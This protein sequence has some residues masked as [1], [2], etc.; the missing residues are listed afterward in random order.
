MDAAQKD[1]I[2]LANVKTI[3]FDT[4]AWNYVSKHSRREALVS[5][6]KESGA[7]VLASVISVGEA[8]RTPRPAV[9]DLCI[10]N[11]AI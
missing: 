10:K 4:S 2:D 9:T 5:A 8:L 6:I 3:Y 1:A 7:V 11:A